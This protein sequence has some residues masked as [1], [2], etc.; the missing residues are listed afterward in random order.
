MCVIA[1]KFS[2]IEFPDIETM[3]NCFTANPD[4]AGFMYPKKGKVHIEKGFMT[5]E[6]FQE[7]YE[8]LLKTFSKS[9]P[10][11]FHF[12]IG[13]HG[14]TKDAGMTHP[15]P[16]GG[17]KQEY[18]Q[19]S[20]EVDLAFA[21]NGIFSFLPSH[22][23]YSD[24][25]IYAKKIL[26]PLAEKWDSFIDTG[27][28]SIILS[29]LGAS[30]LAFMRGNGSI[31][32]FGSWEKYK[33][34]A[35]SNFSYEK[36]VYPLYYGKGGNQYLTNWKDWDETGTG[37]NFIDGFPGDSTRKNS[38]VFI[39]PLEVWETSTGECFNGIDYQE[40][41]HSTLGRIGNKV[42]LYDDYT[43]YWDLLGYISKKKYIEK[44]DNGMEIL[45]KDSELNF[46]PVQDEV[47]RDAP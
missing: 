12:R 9:T 4:G 1:I 46:D 34:V 39:P 16:I 43:D 22:S 44:T 31:E 41:P 21:H 15:F 10:F 33:G 8:K 28:E 47:E 38:L 23:T 6:A 18:T 42:Y 36:P 17:P 29:T 13:T 27:A 24:T 45:D 32:Y 35:Y 25:V 20:Q 37:T 26:E 40:I 7:R 11:I 19:L 2:G 30:K 5:F 3:L 14:K